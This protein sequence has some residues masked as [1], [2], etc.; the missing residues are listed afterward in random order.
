MTRL[1]W[2]PAM[3][4]TLAL[5]AW[6]VPLMMAPTLALAQLTPPSLRGVR[7]LGVGPGE[8]VELEARGTDL[9][10]LSALVF[11]DPRVQVGGLELARPE[12]DDARL[13]RRVKATIRLPQDLAPGPLRFR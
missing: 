11:D 1:P 8:R 12:G 7:P 2:N 13:G 3:P 6:F 9:D 10:G 5:L 4:R